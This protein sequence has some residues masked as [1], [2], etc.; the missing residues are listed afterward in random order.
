MTMVRSLAQKI[1][2]YVVKLASPGTKEWAEALARETDFIE[3][4]W[5][6]LVWSFGSVRVLFDYRSAPIR[7]W[8]EL[9]STVERYAEQKRHLVNNPWLVRNLGWLNMLLQVQIFGSYLLRSTT[10]RDCVGYGIAVLGFLVHAVHCF[11][12]QGEPDVPD[13]DNLPALI[14]F[15]QTE[16]GRE[17][18]LSSPD[19]WIPILSLVTAWVGLMLV[20][21]PVWQTIVG[22][23][24][25]ATLGFLLQLRRNSRR[26]LRQIEMLLDGKD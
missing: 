1:S 25:I 18:S 26:R 13:R 10:T 14:R 2:F 22:V 3:E 6:A 8:D 23:F 21:G 19:F 7:S 4:D 9:T 5:N 20:R 11:L 12:T 16:L 17:V 15:Y 24:F